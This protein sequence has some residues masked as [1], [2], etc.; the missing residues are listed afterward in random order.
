MKN[1]RETKRWSA[2]SVRN[3]CI[4]LDRYTRGDCAAYSK[5]LDFVANNE[6]TLENMQRVAEDIIE[7]SDMSCYGLSFDELVEGVMFDL[8]NDAITYSFERV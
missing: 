3:M 5:M 2:S 1:F 4:K 8:A 6:P 7:H